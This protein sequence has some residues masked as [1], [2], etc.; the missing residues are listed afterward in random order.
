MVA[1]VL[2]LI[3]FALIFGQRDFA[4]GLVRPFIGLVLVLTLAPQLLQAC[5]TSASGDESTT[6]A[7]STSGAAAPLLAFAV[8]ALI[9]WISWRRSA[10]RARAQEA[11]R[12][13]NGSPR[14]RALPP[15]PAEEASP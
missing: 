10:A 2:M 15:P 9:G 6:G 5:A 3:A 14:R 8:L 11:S 4:Q 7:P 12:R 13:R 1:L